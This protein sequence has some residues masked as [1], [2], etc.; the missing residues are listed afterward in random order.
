MLPRIARPELGIFLALWLALM[1]LPRGHFFGDPGSLWHIV[2]GE[3]M[4]ATGELI[5]SD[6]FSFTRGGS[7]WV[8]QSWLAECVL[9][10]LHRIG[11][12]DSI[13][14][15]TMI[16]LAGL[17]T[18]AAHRLL[19][20]GLHPLLVGLI[21]A[22]AITGGAYHL[23]PRPHL[24]T[25]GFL[26]WTF[27]ELCDFE[28]G[29]IPLRRLSRLP[30]LFV[31]WANVH[32][33][34]VAG[35]LTV[36]LAAAGWGL[37]GA[38][39]AEGP[40]T[41][42]RQLLALAG[43]VLA[44]GLAALVN[45]YGLALPRLW[46]ALIGSPVLPRL[47]QEHYSML[48]AGTT[49]LAVVPVA[50]LYLAALAGIPP[51][52]LRVTWLVPVA[53]LIFT[54]L[55]MRNGP[56]FAMVAAIALG[57]MLPAAAWARW[58]ASRGSEVFRTSQEGRAAW[59]R[60][61]GAGSATIGLAGVLLLTS[62]GMQSAGLRVPLLGRGWAQLRADSNPVELL[63]DLRAY[64]RSRPSGTPIFNEMFF[65]GF[66]IYSTPGLKVFIDDRCELYGDRFL[67]DYQD[68]QWDDPAQL[69]R[70]A[71]QYDFDAALTATGS[72]FDRYLA[73]A[74]GWVAVGWSPRASFYRRSESEGP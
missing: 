26:T 71:R 51:R 30:P 60:G 9:A 56:L 36:A 7:P 32:G 13:M 25:L 17:Y 18:W 70:W 59:G 50:L 28:M 45:P 68:A 57:D 11:G 29:R 22:M 6:P 14:A 27:A 40:V 49:A 44:C 23:H 21:L 52:R 62:L 64:E 12:L 33:G 41:R 3:R 43:L 19:R 66:L 42:P 5:H 31:V 73:S 24:L 39:G 47:I 8:P 1:I 72:G 58:L 10:L 34:M 69:D 55:R 16:G 2:V 67:L 46:F 37:A 65:G 48:R 35:V 54:G 61:A 53:W 20:A 63:P 15:A 4:L 74:E 38:V